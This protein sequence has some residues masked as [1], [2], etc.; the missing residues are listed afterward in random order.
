MD[1]QIEQLQTENLFTVIGGYLLLLSWLLFFICLA[2]C[3]PALRKKGKAFSRSVRSLPQFSI[4]VNT[5]L[6]LFVAGMHVYGMVSGD[7]YYVIAQENV[8]EITILLFPSI[9]TIAVSILFLHRTTETVEDNH[10]LNIEKR[11]GA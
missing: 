10:F 9:A 4:M 11:N 5:I 6:L 7:S 2:A 1:L 3:A 8:L